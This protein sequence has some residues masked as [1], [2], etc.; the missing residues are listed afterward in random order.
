LPRE[1]LILGRYGIEDRR[2]A[3]KGDALTAWSSI[4]LPQCPDGPLLQHAP[5]RHY[6]YAK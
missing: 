5:W 4:L 1:I 3:L 6:F 2:S